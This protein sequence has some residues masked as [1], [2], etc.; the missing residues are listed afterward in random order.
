MALGVVEG[1]VD[2]KYQQRCPGDKYTMHTASSGW[3]VITTC[4]GELS[5]KADVV[6]QWSWYCLN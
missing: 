1:C 3:F 4:V 5:V 6:I 2:L